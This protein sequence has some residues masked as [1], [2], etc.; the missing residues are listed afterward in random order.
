MLAM[1]RSNG[2]FG[3]ATLFVMEWYEGTAFKVARYT[4][5]QV[6]PLKLPPAD[7]KYGYVNESRILAT[8]SRSM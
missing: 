3:F 5:N 8:E 2:F 1:K 6:V 4:D 7:Y